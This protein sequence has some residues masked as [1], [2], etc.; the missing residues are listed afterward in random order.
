MTLKLSKLKKLAKVKGIPE[1]DIEEAGGAGE[2][3]DVKN[4]LITLMLKSACVRSCPS[5][6]RARSKKIDLNA[7]TCEVC[8]G[9]IRPPG[10]E[11]LCMD[12]Q[13]NDIH[14]TP[15]KDIDVTAEMA[16]HKAIKEEVKQK[17][18]EDAAAEKESRRKAAEKE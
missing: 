5:P 10:H 11:G 6:T 13:C 15:K 16:R 8:I 2:E 4:V 1:K 14:P 9:C 7:Q 12:G 18:E 3:E 17:L